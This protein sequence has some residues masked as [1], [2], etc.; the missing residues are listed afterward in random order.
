M[1]LDDGSFSAHRSIPTSRL[2]LSEL[3]QTHKQIITSMLATAARGTFNK[4]SVT[5]KVSL[6]YRWGPSCI[7]L[8]G[9]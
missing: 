3:R 1:G 4:L 9:Q 5:D 8:Q 6:I 2:L 7:I